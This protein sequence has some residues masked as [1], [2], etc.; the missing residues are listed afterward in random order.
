MEIVLIKPVKKLGR[1]GEVKDVARGFAVNFLLPYGFALPATPGFVKEAQSRVRKIVRNVIPDLSEME[2]L[3]A[4][5]DGLSLEF[6]KKVSREGKLFGSVKISDIVDAIEAKIG[7]EI[8]EKY[9]HL[10]EPLKF[11]GDHTVTIKVGEATA[12]VAVTI[13][14]EEV[15]ADKG[16]KNKKMRA[17][18]VVKD[19]KAKK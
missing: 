11:I 7:R 16:A 13:H 9:V 18:G 8:E 3:M 19:K 5:I 4:K 15:K 17:K 1:P 12:K 6:V 10:K 2:T 14:G